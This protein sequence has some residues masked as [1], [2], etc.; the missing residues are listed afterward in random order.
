AIDRC[1]GGS[2]NIANGAFKPDG[3]LAD[4]AGRRAIHTVKRDY[5]AWNIGL[6]HNQWIRWL[7]PVNSFTISAQQ[8]W[9]HRNGTHRLP[10][11][12]LP[13]NVLNERDGIAAR[14]R[15]FIQPPAPGSGGNPQCDPKKG[16]AR[17]GCSVW[18]WNAQD[19]LTTLSIS[20]QYLG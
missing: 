1:L 14:Q 19:W 13:T 12:G 8:F 2:L 7:N 15:R 11:P 6:D 3:A 5:L 18:I 4:Q 16:G 10:H 17:D 9:L 20:T